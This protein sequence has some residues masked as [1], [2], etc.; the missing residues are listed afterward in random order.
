MSLAPTLAGNTNVL[1]QRTPLRITRGVTLDIAVFI[2]AAL[3]CLALL[4]NGGLEALLGAVTGTA[5]AKRGRRLNGAFAGLWIGALF[6][7]FFHGALV[8]ALQALP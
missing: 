8:A 6:A 1:R 4:P 2:G 7:A 5:F 3:I